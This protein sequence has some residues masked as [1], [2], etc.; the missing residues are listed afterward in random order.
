MIFLH[1][2]KHQKFST[3]RQ[4]HFTGHIARYAK[5]TQN[6]KFVIKKKG[7]MKLIFCIQI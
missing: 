7:G 2:D 3:R 4:Y 6:S 1:E 5:S